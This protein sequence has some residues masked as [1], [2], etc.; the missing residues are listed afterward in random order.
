MTSNN[1]GSRQDFSIAQETRAGELQK[2]VS[3]GVARLLD[4]AKP[5]GKA[6]TTQLLIKLAAYAIVVAQ[7]QGDKNSVYDQLEGIMYILRRQRIADSTTTQ[8]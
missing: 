3:S 4:E 5:A 7:H 2:L 8:Q 6:E 1:S